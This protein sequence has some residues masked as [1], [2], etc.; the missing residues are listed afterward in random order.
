[1]NGHGVA[2]GALRDQ[3]AHPADLRVGLHPVGDH[4]RN[5]LGGLD[6]LFSALAGRLDGLLTEYGLPVFGGGLRVRQ[7]E[8]VRRADVGRVVLVGRFRVRELLV[9]ERG[10]DGRYLLGGRGRLFTAAANEDRGLTELR[11][12]DRGDRLFAG[13]PPETDNRDTE[14]SRLQLLPVPVP[15]GFEIIGG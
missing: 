12:G 1:V 7:V 9:G 5:V 3:L 14:R 13:P 10:L 11:V 4:Q 15:D 8:R 6:E 2:D